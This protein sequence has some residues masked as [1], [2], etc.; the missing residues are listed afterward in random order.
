MIIQS[1]YRKSSFL[2]IMKTRRRKKDKES[3]YKGVKIKP[4]HTAIWIA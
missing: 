1:N 3:L 4:V 2:I